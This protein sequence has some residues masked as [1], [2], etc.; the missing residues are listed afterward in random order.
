MKIMVNVDTNTLLRKEQ[1]LFCKNKTVKNWFCQI[2]PETDINILEVLIDNIFAMF[3]GRVFQQAVGIPVSSNC[4]PLLADLFLYMYE[5]DSIHVLL[6]KKKIARSF[7]CTRYIEDILSTN[8][9]Q[10]GEY[11]DRIYSIKLEIIDTTDTARNWQW[12]RMRKILLHDKTD[13][14]KFHILNFPFSSSTCIWSIHLLVHAIF[15]S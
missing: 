7:K 9:S 8:K 10:F 2:I 1:I 4:A 3:G 13:D 6:K 11:V 15:D 14:F 12:C 5:T